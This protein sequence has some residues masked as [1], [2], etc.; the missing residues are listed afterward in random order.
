MPIDRVNLSGHTSI[1]MGSVVLQ[2]KY[3]LTGST[4]AAT[5]TT[6]NEINVIGL[7]SLMY[8]IQLTTAVPNV[9]WT[10]MFSVQNITSGGASAPNWLAF[11]NGIVVAPSAVSTFTI[12][13]AVA[14]AAIRVT[15]PS[16][17]PAS[18]VEVTVVIT[19]GA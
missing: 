10:P 9:V 19:G 16:A 12:R 2:R 6:I 14:L 13:A 11:N 1:S 7:P 17:T 5:S 8:W 18:S 4:T 15:I 3:T